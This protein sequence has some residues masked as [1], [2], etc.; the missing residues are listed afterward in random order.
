M[1]AMS[2]TPLQQVT[3]IVREIAQDPAIDL[4]QTSR[5][6]DIV[7]IDSMDI[8]SIAVEVECCF[9]ILFDVEDIEQ[10]ITVDDLLRLIATKRMPAAA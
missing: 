6:D 7:G 1:D 10:L 9:G 4:T 5:L 8:V 2:T 3:A